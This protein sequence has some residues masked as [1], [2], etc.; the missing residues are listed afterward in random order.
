MNTQ[1]LITNLKTAFETQFPESYIDVCTTKLIGLHIWIEFAL[2]KDKSEWNH[3]IIRNDAFHG[4]FI[5]EIN[6]DGTLPE[7]LE[8]ELSIGGNIT[9]KRFDRIKTG[10]RKIK[11]N[12]TQVSTKFEKYF[13]KAKGI[14]VENRN[15]LEPMIQ[16]KF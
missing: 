9:T 12:P 15:E 14:L 16:G 13:K 5:I 11:G 8:T 3:G 10:Y 2:G 6:D 1:E 4:R 7:K